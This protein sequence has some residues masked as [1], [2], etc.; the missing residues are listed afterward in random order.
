[1]IPSYGGL[2]FDYNA[3]KTAIMSYKA[4]LAHRNG[5][6]TPDFSIIP[7]LPNKSLRRMIVKQKPGTQDLSCVNAWQRKL[8]LNITPFFNIA[9][10]CTK[11]P[12]LIGLH[13]KII[14]N[15]FNS[16]YLL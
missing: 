16:N 15:I 8:N 1:M 13:F 2:L 10:L 4:K 12:R 11:E 9:K 14:H 7:K 5:S 6:P 3:I